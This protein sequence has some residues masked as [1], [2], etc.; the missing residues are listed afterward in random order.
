MSHPS[1]DRLSDHAY[2]LEASPAEIDAHLAECPACCQTVW[3][4]QRERASL[5]QALF[6]PAPPTLTLPQ[7]A[8][9]W[10]I[11]AAAAIL[12]VGLSAAAVAGSLWRR[13]QRAERERAAAR[14]ELNRRPAPDPEP[15]FSETLAELCRAEVDRSETEIIAHVELS[16]EGRTNLRAALEGAAGTPPD[17]LELFARG[18]IDEGAL[19][20]TDLLA[21]LDGELRRGL[22][23]PDYEKLVEYLD[24]ARR[25]AAGLLAQRAGDQ[26]ERAVRL[27]PDQRDRLQA[28]LVEQTSWR[29]DIVF[30]PERGQRMVAL[31]AVAAGQARASIVALLDAVQRTD[32]D[33]Y[34][35]RERA[36]LRRRDS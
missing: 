9:P 4:L 16:E 34:V 24:K 36:A 1:A 22:P 20:R 12:L 11:A 26:I 33:A 19:A 30:L 21:S 2:G 17:V 15:S 3:R 10:R 27:R 23:G 5:E 18:E 25:A 8:A 32:F 35:A 13:T 6:E 28:L 14:A 31:A 29:C 7:P